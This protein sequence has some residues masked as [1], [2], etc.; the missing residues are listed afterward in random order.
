LT[1]LL[2]AIKEIE[3]K[4]KAYQNHRLAVLQKMR[5]NKFRKKLCKKK[6]HLFD[7]P[8]TFLNRYGVI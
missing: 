5:K 3:S 6:E 4:Q 8:F 1:A 2:D 7:A